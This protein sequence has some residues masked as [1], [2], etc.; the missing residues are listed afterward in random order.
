VLEDANVWIP[1]ADG[2]RLA[3]RIWR[4][5]DRTPVPALLEYLPYRKRFGTVARDTLT[6]PYLVSHGYASVRVDIRG[7]GESDGVLEDEYS[8]S[9]LADGV[10]VID[11]IAAQPWCDGNVGM[12]G[13]SWGGFNALQIAALAPPALKAIVTLC[14]T[15]DRYA[16]DIHR[17]GGCVLSDELSWASVMFALNTM[18][19]DPEIVGDRWREMWFE[20]LEGSGLWLD[21]WLRHQ[22][23][24]EYWQHGSVC[25]DYSAIRCPVYA[26]SG[27]ADGYSNAVFR[28]LENL[29]V[30]RKGLIG[31]WAHA[32]PH[33]ATPG[34][35]IGF[36]QE[37]VRWWDKWLKGIESGIMDEPMLRVWMQNEVK[38][39]PRHEY[40]PGRWIAESEW[41]AAR[42]E[43]TAFGLDAS[44]SLGETGGGTT[45]VTSPLW[46]GRDGGKWCSYAD[47]PDQ[48]GDQ[49]ADDSGS[50]V[51]DTAP[52]AEAVEIL[53]APEAVLEISADRPVA[54]VVVR[55][56]SVDESGASTRV[57]YGVLNLTHR[58]SHVAPS[59]LEPGH[60]SRVRI[61]MNDVA[62]RF[63]AGTRIRLAVS[64]SYW[65]LVWP[66]PDLAT[67]QIDCGHSS[68][69]LPYRSAD[70]SDFS[71]AEFESPEG[72][73]PSRQTVLTPGQGEWRVEHDL[74]TD[75]HTVEVIDDSGTVRL[76]DI[77]LEV[78]TSAVERYS[79]AGADPNSA[80]G[81]VRTIRT[82][83]RG[84]WGVET[85]TSTLLS[86][87]DDRF[88]ID[89]ELVALENGRETHRQVWHEEIPRRLV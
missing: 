46:V 43:A 28:L 64:T 77:G 68:L 17:M 27:W 14:S 44:G 73:V 2:G 38:P 22:H 25:E 65:P 47:T 84:D 62:Q 31:P 59:P 76:D 29:S 39:A 61:K 20:R 70:P 18:P 79:I 63:E 33:I 40:R 7:S 15:D 41:P 69:I 88:V 21:K 78:G 45:T 13:I 89:A 9:E 75:T 49:R 48:P 23:R 55:L 6:H 58:D 86:C 8:V 42:I 34:P 80:R 51:F 30:P 57:T 66:A 82:M 81:E 37:I 85:T 35:A 87:T 83:R 4:P 54:Q 50:T 12:M 3:A 60:F 1:L 16:D 52:L 53:G 5:S 71:L 24:D 56:C 36:A 19:P 11:W 67:L 26:V 74:G 32:Y 72:A 10:A